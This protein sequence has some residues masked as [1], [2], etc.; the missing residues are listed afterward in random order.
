MFFLSIL[1]G[2]S[3]LGP[4]IMDLSVYQRRYFLH[5]LWSGGR[6]ECD[7]WSVSSLTSYGLSPPTLTA[8]SQN[9][10]SRSRTY[11]QHLHHGISS[12]NVTGLQHCRTWDLDTQRVYHVKTF[13]WHKK[14]KML[15][16]TGAL[17]YFEEIMR[18]QERLSPDQLVQ[19]VME[20]VSGDLLPAPLP[21]L[22]T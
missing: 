3:W 20:S 18:S 5:F 13:Q 6:G 12:I 9:S 16:D 19:G 11:L 7:V 15:R 2:P 22:L 4:V 17:Y 10:S 21:A 14:V 1:S 8:Q